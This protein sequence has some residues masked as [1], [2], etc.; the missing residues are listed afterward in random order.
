MAS[1]EEQMNYANKVK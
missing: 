1:L